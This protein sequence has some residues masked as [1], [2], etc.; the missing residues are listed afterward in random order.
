L[1]A[2]TGQQRSASSWDFRQVFNSFKKEDKDN[3]HV[4]NL[5]DSDNKKNRSI[6][7][8]LMTL[9]YLEKRKKGEF[10]FPLLGINLYKVY[11]PRLKGKYSLSELKL[12][13][14]N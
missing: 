14:T 6:I 13:G 7:G 2:F 10:S 9:G 12:I 4:I 5:I 8:A 3:Q 11:D 1:N